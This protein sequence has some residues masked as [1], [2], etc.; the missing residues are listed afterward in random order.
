MTF[1]SPLPGAQP[2]FGLEK[3]AGTLILPQHAVVALPWGPQKA[4]FPK[5]AFLQVPGQW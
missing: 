2:S 1:T 3:V 4:P 5:A